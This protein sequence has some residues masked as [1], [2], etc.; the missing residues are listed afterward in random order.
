MEINENYHNVVDRLPNRV[1]RFGE[2]S[3]VGG[4]IS[5]DSFYEN[6]RFSPSVLVTF[7]PRKKV[8]YSF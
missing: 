5:S 8:M 3:P 1:A 2:F 6:F 7:F 4:L